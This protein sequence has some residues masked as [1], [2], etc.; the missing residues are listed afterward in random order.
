MFGA[1]I[2][3]AF[4]EENNDNNFSKRLKNK[5]KKEIIRSCII[6]LLATIITSMNQYEIMPIKISKSIIGT[7]SSEEEFKE[8]VKNGCYTHLYIYRMEDTV[9]EQLKNLVE[10]AYI[11]NDILYKIN[12]IN[13]Q[14]FLERVE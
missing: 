9:K 4:E 2:F 10:D 6:I 1:T 12:E 8:V 14:I 7:F 3:Y 5:N 11:G 13:G